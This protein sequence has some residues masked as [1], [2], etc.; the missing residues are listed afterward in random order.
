ML[1]VVA[2]AEV[3]GADWPQW[4]GPARDG[5][6]KETGLLKA[7]PADGP[8]LMWQVEDLGGGYSTPS[9]AGGRLYVM[10]N[11]GVE[12]ESV[13]ALEAKDGKKVWSTRVGKVG[14]PEQR[15]SYPAAR[16][17]P[18]VDGT[19]VYV[20]NKESLWCYDI[21]DAAAGK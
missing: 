7:W 6:S 18:T 13:L 3:S 11:K 2:G 12:E 8:K 17:T 9:V 10:S 15:P 20:R 5:M 21:R 14:N 4:R 16:S 1:V 19:R